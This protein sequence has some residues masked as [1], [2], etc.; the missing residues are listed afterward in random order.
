MIKLLRVEEI[1]RED[2]LFPNPSW[3]LVEGFV[4]RLD[5]TSVTYLTLYKTAGVNDD[6]YLWAGGGGEYYICEYISGEKRYRLLSSE[7]PES[8][9]IVAI[10]VINTEN[11]LKKYCINFEETLQN[12]KYFFENGKVNPDYPWDIQK[13]S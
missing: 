11:I 4:Y 10:P 12:V 8:E 1:E 13:R 7:N 2:D 5:G 6:E 3:E 9:E